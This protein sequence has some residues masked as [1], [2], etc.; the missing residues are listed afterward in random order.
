MMSIILILICGI[1]F[2][3][4][5]LNLTSAIN[6][7]N[8]VKQ[9][10]IEYR[11]YSDGGGS[12]IILP[13]GSRDIHANG[14]DQELINCI[15]EYNRYLYIA[16]ESTVYAEHAHER[17]VPIN[18]IG[19]EWLT[20]NGIA[21]PSVNNQEQSIYEQQTNRKANNTIEKRASLYGVFAQDDGSKCLEGDYTTCSTGSCYTYMQ[22]FESVGAYNGAQV[23]ELIWRIWPHHSCTGGNV[24][25]I[26]IVSH[27]TSACQIRDTYSWKAKLDT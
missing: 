5:Y 17:S 19:E 11:A 18:A 16:V 27:A 25:T 10:Q 8:C 9:T 2:S 13:P 15:R 23:Y 3:K 7:V 12:I 6:F 4:A 1:S 26:T 20:N 24:R 22:K 14:T 21:S